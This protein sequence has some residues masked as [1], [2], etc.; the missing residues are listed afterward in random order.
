MR[1]DDLVRR[2][3]Q[4]DEIISSAVPPSAFGSLGPEAAGFI[5]D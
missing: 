5:S 2:V 4:P 1:P 3:R